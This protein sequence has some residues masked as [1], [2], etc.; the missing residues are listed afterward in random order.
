MKRENYN[1]KQCGKFDSVFAKK[2]KKSY[3]RGSVED[4]VSAAEGYASRRGI[5]M[6]VYGGYRGVGIMPEIP[7]IPG[8]N[9]I[10]VKPEGKIDCWD[11]KHGF[12]SEQLK[13]FGLG[14]KA[15]RGKT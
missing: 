13:L 10:E 9:F 4:A 2:N 12:E 14:R 6:Y 8:Q 1:V 3:H 5:S 11:W 15:K 7:E